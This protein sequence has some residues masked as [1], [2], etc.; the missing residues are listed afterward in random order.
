MCHLNNPGCRF[1]PES[2]PPN[3]GFHQYLD[4]CPGT[5]CGLV[6]QKMYQGNKSATLSLK[7]LRP[8]RWSNCLWRWKTSPQTTFYPMNDS[9]SRVQVENLHGWE[10]VFVLSKIEG[11]RFKIHPRNWTWKL[12]RSPWKNGKGDSFWKPSCFR[13]YVLFYCGGASMKQL[14]Q[15]SFSKIFQW[16]DWW[17]DVD[18]QIRW[19]LMT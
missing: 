17:N 6:F 8:S 11:G 16:N 14:E 1:G 2:K 10:G 4:P 13:F 5:I 3:P 18:F 12:K 9:L 7:K 15:L 19:F